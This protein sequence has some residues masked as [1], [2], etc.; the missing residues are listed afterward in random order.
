MNESQDVPHI[1]ARK[2]KGKYENDNP[3]LTSPHQ[4]LIQTHMPHYKYLH[5]KKQTLDHIAYL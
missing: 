3:T 1:H 4:N 5:I 2:Y